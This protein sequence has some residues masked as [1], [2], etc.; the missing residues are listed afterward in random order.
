MTLL[1]ELL[2]LSL[3]WRKRLT[4]RRVTTALPLEL[5]HERKL[6]EEAAI[7]AALEAAENGRAS[8]PFLV[9]ASLRD[10]RAR[11]EGDLCEL[12]GLRHATVM[13]NLHRLRRA[14][15][16]E[17]TYVGSF[18]LWSATRKGED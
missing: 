7:E 5:E 8:A 13:N 12:T 2:G 1:E 17:Q 15:E 6:V 3:H 14:G 9:M 18:R 16:V 11:F 10:G 4:G